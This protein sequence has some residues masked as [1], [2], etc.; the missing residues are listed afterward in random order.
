MQDKDLAYL[1]RT[2]SSNERESFAISLGQTGTNY[3]VGQLVRMA[4]GRRRFWFNWFDY[5]DQLIGIQALGET[6]SERALEF[7]RKTYQKRETVFCISSRKCSY[8]SGTGVD[9]DFPNAGNLRRKLK[10]RC[11]S[12]KTTEIPFKVDIFQDEYSV[13]EGKD[14]E[15]HGCITKAIEKLEIDLA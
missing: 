11:W 1:L 4:R 9:C 8:E 13:D 7:L 12:R 14:S 3:A 10:Y 6:R 5:R 2:C 15:L